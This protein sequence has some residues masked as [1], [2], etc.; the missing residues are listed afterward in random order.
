MLAYKIALNYLCKTK[1]KLELLSEKQQVKAKSNARINNLLIGGDWAIDEQFALSYLR[2]YELDLKLRKDGHEISKDEFAK[3]KAE[4]LPSLIAFE[5]E[6]AETFGFTAEQIAARNKQ[7]AKIPIKGAMFA[8]D[9]LSSPGATTIAQDIRTAVTSANIDAIVLEVNSGGGEVMAG[10]LIQNAVSEAVKKKPVVA[11]VHNAGSAALM[12]ILP[13]SEIVMSSEMSGIGS[14]GMLVSFDKIRL[15]LESEFTEE[16]YSNLSPDKN[17]SFRSL[18]EGDTGPLKAELDAKTAIFH[19]QVKKFRPLVAEMQESTLRGGF[20]NAKDGIKRGLADRL[21]TMQTALNRAVTLSRGKGGVGNKNKTKYKAINNMDLFKLI[22]RLTGKHVETEESAI[23]AL[24]TANLV[25]AS[26]YNELNDKIE[27]LSNIAQANKESLSLIE[28]VA[29]ENENRITA[30][31]ETVAAISV[32]LEE[33]ATATVGVKEEVEDSVS[34]KMAEL[35]AR[36]KAILA[37]MNKL[38]SE[39]SGVQLKGGEGET[40]IQ[41]A[42]GEK[43]IEGGEIKIGFKP[44]SL[45]EGKKVKVVYN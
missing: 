13:S 45:V 26:Q 25:D 37:E 34:E 22:G 28:N 14:I 1:R 32:D 40:S 23:E 2:Q 31:S 24:E 42:T 36:N 21:G 38:K 43:V 12:A 30:I 15:A 10:A 3:R 18:K 35:E 6:R 29:K 44:G 4:K 16:I 9:Q 17:K 19:G 27:A 11:L 8:E 39:K 5:G 20:F 41:K 33:A 7:V